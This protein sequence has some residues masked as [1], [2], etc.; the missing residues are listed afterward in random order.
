MRLIN[1]LDNDIKVLA[2]GVAYTPKTLGLSGMQW[3][4]NGIG[5]RLD[6]SMSN[7]WGIPTN[8]LMT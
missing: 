8:L 4:L 5:R 6:G 1:S 7:L 2:F 3:I